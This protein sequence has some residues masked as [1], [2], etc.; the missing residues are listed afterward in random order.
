[1]FA[2][3]KLAGRGYAVREAVSGTGFVDFLITF[4]SGLV[5]VVELKVLKT[6]EVPGPAQL[7][8]YMSHK[9]RKVGWLVFLDTRKPDRKGTVPR[10]ISL[11]A[12]TIRSIVID[13]NPTPPHL[14][15]GHVVAKD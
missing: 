13:I 5:H 11:A 4:S 1:V 14:L 8:T 15:S 7:A 10:S 6:R 3:A 2:R 9:N 12:G